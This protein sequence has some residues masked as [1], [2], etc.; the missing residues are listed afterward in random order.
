VNLSGIEVTQALV[1]PDPEFVPEALTAVIAHL[2][3]LIDSVS[4]SGTLTICVDGELYNKVDAK[5]QVTVGT[6]SSV[7]IQDPQLVFEPF[8]VPWSEDVDFLVEVV[9]SENPET[10]LASD[11]KLD[12]QFSLDTAVPALFYVRIDFLPSGLGPPL[13]EQVNHP[14]GD[15]F[16]RAVLPISEERWFYRAA[17]DWELQSAGLE[18]IAPITV[19]ENDCDDTGSTCVNGDQQLQNLV[20]H[21]DLVVFHRLSLIRNRIMGPHENGVSELVFVHGWISDSDALTVPVVEDNG[22]ASGPSGRVGYSTAKGSNGQ[23]MYVHEL[24]HNVAPTSTIV[25]PG[26]LP[27]TAETGALGWDVA[28]HLPAGWT[29][30]GITEDD[31]RKTEDLHPIRAHQDSAVSWISPEEYKYVADYFESEIL[32]ELPLCEGGVDPSTYDGPPCYSENNILFSAGLGSEEPFDPQTTEEVEL[33]A[34]FQ[35]WQIPWRSQPTYTY[36]NVTLE[37]LPFSLIFLRNGEE[38]A[39]VPFDALVYP[40]PSREDGEDA[41]PRL[42]YFEVLVPREIVGQPD[43][44]EIDFLGRQRLDF[45][46]TAEIQAEFGMPEDLQEWE[47]LDMWDNVDAL[48]FLGYDG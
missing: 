39:R 37:D 33:A 11:V 15:A 1:L 4:V 8:A 40:H 43:T 24:L 10:I 22:V 46:T 28:S 12:Q 19:A 31:Q 20:P 36:S 17:N 45:M 14:A 3:P 42:G 41:P 34:R 23:L 6:N 38:I 48:Q 13:H 30:T 35:V 26:H 2:E 25:G 29:G 47:G 18:R 44:I 27:V 5:Q 7:G 32:S 21:E 16:A 9:S